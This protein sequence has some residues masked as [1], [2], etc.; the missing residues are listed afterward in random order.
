VGPLNQ[1]DGGIL[2]EK[3]F[4]SVNQNNMVEEDKSCIVDI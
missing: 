3:S 4:E 2:N 1:K